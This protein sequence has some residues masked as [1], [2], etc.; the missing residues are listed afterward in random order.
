MGSLYDLGEGVYIRGSWTNPQTGVPM[1]PSAVTV[2][3]LPPSGLVDVP[4]VKVYGVDPEVV[5]DSTG[6]FSLLLTAD[7]V[8]L[9]QYRWE[10]EN[11]A[12]AIQEGSFIVRGS[13]LA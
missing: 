4:I 3:Y 13:D 7:E 9:W 2:R 8:G 1:D 5:H 6:N 10:G 12:P 11:V